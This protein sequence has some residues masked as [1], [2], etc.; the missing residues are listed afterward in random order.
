MPLQNIEA[1]LFD[2]DET[3]IHNTRSFEEIAR[4]TFA[5]FPAEL[6]HVSFDEYW[7][8]LWSKAVDM[9]CMMVDGALSGDVARRYTLI[10]TLR[11]LD[12]DTALAPQLL[13]R[14]DASMLASTRVLEDTYPVLKRLREA[15]F[16][17]GIVTNGYSTMQRMKIAHHAL[18]EHVDFALVSEEAGVHKPDPAIF[19]AALAQTGCAPDRVLFVGDT[20]ENDYIGARNA[21]LKA[22]LID[23]DRTRTGC[24]VGVEHYIQ[25][26]A[27]VLPLLGLP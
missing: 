23:H 16:Q 9:W 27:E 24:G 22:V 5:A 26:L 20:F 6:G 11:A 19:G 25:R 14:T 4:D 2:M 12:A 7:T 17:L 21:G 15:G 10:N 3:L 1:V 8:A 13:A 18:H